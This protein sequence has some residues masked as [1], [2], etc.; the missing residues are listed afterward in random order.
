MC[1]VL[2][3]SSCASVDQWAKATFTPPPPKMPSFY[4]L[5]ENGKYHYPEGYG[6]DFTTDFD[7]YQEPRPCPCHSRRCLHD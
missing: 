1:L 5:D 6:P 3:L 2:L 4:E 7:D